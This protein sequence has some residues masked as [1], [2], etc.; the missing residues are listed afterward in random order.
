MIYNLNNLD[1]NTFDD[2]TYDFC[3]IGA[4]FAGITL[5]LNL[6]KKYKILLLEGGDYDFTVE[7]QDI[8]KGKV[9]GH[10]YWRLED[11]RIRCFGGS[12]NVW[13]KW[14]IPYEERDFEKKPYAKLS[15][16]P[17]S[18]KDLDPYLEQ[19]NEIFEMSKAFKPYSNAKGWDDV[20]KKPNDDFEGFY[21]PITPVDFKEKF[22]PEIKKSKNIDCYL[23]A[24][25]TDMTLSDD[26]STVI[27]VEVKNYNK[28]TFTPKAKTFIL[29]TGGMENARLLLSF[30]KQCKNGIGNDND[31]VG[32]YFCEHPQFQAG[33]FILEDHTKALFKSK[34]YHFEH[35]FLRPTGKY[36]EENKV[37]NFGIRI[38]TESFLSKDI[39][40]KTLSRTFKDKVKGIVCESEWLTGMVVTYYKDGASLLC[41]TNDLVKRVRD[42]R[43]VYNGEQ[44]SNASSR[45]LLSKNEVDKFGMKR[46]EFDWNFTKIDLETA[47]KS[48]LSFAK[49]FAMH[50]IGRLKVDDWILS[51][52]VDFP[53]IEHGRP[54]PH[55]M[56]TTRMSDTPKEGVVDVNCKL[57]GIDNFYIGG[58]SIFSSSGEVNPTFTIVQM[59]L[60]L[61]KY[62]N[63]SQSAN[64]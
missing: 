47:R 45:I 10:D 52:K 6:D 7:S 8:Y 50:N 62:F 5:A 43:I 46:I 33:T 39:K 3:I 4:G 41:E 18:K 26:H 14:A 54:G 27:G 2:K 55:H 13:G 20:L 15:G 11:S 31:Q 44:I 57:F 28:D 12:S 56:C 24:N 16:W 49:V 21:I 36:M 32:R 53:T 63:E 48:V 61:A 17:I 30:N 29:A 59:T 51:D 25:L 23:N 22:G 60:R 40:N 9:V 58:S 64:S 1:K 38:E 37:L 35:K 19:T 34:E 42:G